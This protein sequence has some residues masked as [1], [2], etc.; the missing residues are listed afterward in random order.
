MGKAETNEGH[1]L[2]VKEG[3]GN[4]WLWLYTG[5]VLLGLLLIYAYRASHLP[6]AGEKGRWAWIAVF[7]A[8]L[9]FGFYWFISL[10]VRW[11]PLY[12]FPFRD[13]LSQRF[14]GKLPGVDIFIFTADPVIEPPTM[15]I[16]TVLSVLAY[17]HPPEKLTI[18]LSDD[19]CSIFTFYALLEAS[20]FA[21]LWIPFCK[22]FNVHPMAP[23]VF[24][25]KL[26][27]PLDDPGFSEW[28]A[29]E[30]LYRDMESRIDAA[31]KV[32]EIS[33]DI[34]TQHE[35]FSEWCSTTTTK[36]YQA[37]VKILIDG[38]DQNARDSAG[39]SLPTVVYVAREKHQK[40]HHNF[41][42]GAVNALLRVS[43]EISNGPIIL[44]L[45]CDM[46][47]NTS[48]SI[49][50]ALCFFMDEEKGQEIAFVQFPQTFENITKN[51][52]YASSLKAL[53]WVDFHGMDG[54]GGPVFTGTCCFHSRECL[55]G[56]KYS[57]ANK[58]ELKGERPKIQEA[59]T[60]NLEERAKALATCTYEEKTQWGKERP[61]IQEASTMN[62]EERAKALATCTYEE[63][64]QWGKEMGLIYGCPVEDVITGFSIQCR[65]WKSAYVNPEREA[66]L[67][68]AP[69]TLSQALVQHKRWSE[70]DLQIFLSSIVPFFM[71]MEK[72]SLVFKCSTPCTAFGLSTPFQPSP[73]LPFR[74]F[75]SSIAFL[76]TPVFT[77][78]GSYHLYL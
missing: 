54:Q 32:G 41:K 14:E 31:V 23:S 35:G 11:S 6:A 70:G 50:D 39:H 34:K 13:R 73:M 1:L 51:D 77:A 72:Q 42:A 75:A 36:D 61:K 10:S 8:E 43:A 49:R 29:M 65:G 62:L 20:N 2:E 66:F 57:K 26:S 60:R 55:N 53:Q 15:V 38:R 64:T 37:I 33:E 56:K 30:K 4:V 18:Y 7:A 5:S 3:K 27:V 12:R 40:Y 9:W 47:V 71:V 76:Y 22:K 63:K 68:R 44:I 24:F 28:K 45:D 21:K 58:I 46:L 16:N 52:L 59:S 19:G 48:K 74:L 17:D 67:G 25:S 69:S 78:F